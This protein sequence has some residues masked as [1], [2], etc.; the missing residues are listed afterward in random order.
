MI[1]KEKINY[2]ITLKEVLLTELCGMLNAFSAAVVTMQKH[3]P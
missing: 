3:C 1:E 2:A